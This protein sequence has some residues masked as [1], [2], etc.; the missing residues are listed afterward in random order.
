MRLKLGA[1]DTLTCSQRTRAGWQRRGLFTLADQAGYNSRARDP[2]VNPDNCFSR[3]FYLRCRSQPKGWGVMKISTR[4]CSRLT[5][6]SKTDQFCIS[7]FICE[8]TPAIF[9]TDRPPQTPFVLPA[10]FWVHLE[11]V[12]EI[13]L[14]L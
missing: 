10:C 11:R 3:Y 9:L 2:L 13:L 8:S 1:G 5:V 4:C 6:W 12:M 14:W 7:S